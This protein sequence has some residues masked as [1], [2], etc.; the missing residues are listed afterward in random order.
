MNKSDLLKSIAQKGYDVGFGAKKHFA[1][2]DIIEK[3]PGFISFISMAVG[4]Y[5]LVIKSLSAEL[6][7]A[8]FIVL[9]IVGLYINLSDHKKAEYEKSGSALTKDFNELKALYLE[10]KGSPDD[11]PLSEYQKR[12][13]EIENQFYDNSISKQIMF[14]NWYAHYKFFWEHQIDWID[15]QLKF[16]FL[17]DKIPLSFM[18]VLVLMSAILIAPCIKT[19]CKPCTPDSPQV[20]TSPLQPADKSEQK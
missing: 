10:V 12:L 8:T 19:L 2:Y 5:A 4:V 15:E 14:S 17:R 3:T 11:A 7:S 20:Q 16:H 18:F 13:T 1:T 6:I 9:G